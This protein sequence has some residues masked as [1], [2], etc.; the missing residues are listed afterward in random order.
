MPI[1]NN[2]RIILTPIPGKEKPGIDQG[3]TDFQGRK[4]TP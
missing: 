2:E 4:N 3:R 1:I